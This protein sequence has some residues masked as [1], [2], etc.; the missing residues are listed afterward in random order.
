MSD[1]YQKRKK[2]DSWYSYRFMANK[3][4]MDAGYLVKVFQ[5]KLNLPLKY[6]EP[7]GVLL[8]LQANELAYFETLI[9][10]DRSKDSQEMKELFQKL[11]D[12]RET[13][14]QNI[15]YDRYEYFQSWVHSAIRALVD[16]VNISEDFKEL[17]GLCRPKIGPKEAKYSVKLLERLGLIYKNSEG[18]WRSSYS[19]LS[20]GESWRSHAIQEY[21]SQMIKMAEESLQRHPKEKRDISSITLTL[22][23]SDLAEARLRISDFRKK[24]INWVS[25]N[26][27]EEGVYQFNIQ[28]FPLTKSVSNN[29]VK[30]V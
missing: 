5:G 24:M 14:K 21:Q 25:G 11:Q 18:F 26:S 12:L 22:K 10:F 30:N 13:P 8:E 19:N 9:R 23:E 1:Y 17:G 3:I 16:I 20:T 2:Q 27:N 15:E 29:E 7:L 6:I 28:L 4:G